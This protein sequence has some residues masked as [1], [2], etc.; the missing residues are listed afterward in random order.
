MISDACF[1]ALIG[2]YSNCIADERFGQ[3]SPFSLEHMNEIEYYIA[4]VCCLVWEMSHS[5][6]GRG[7]VQGHSVR[8]REAKGWQVPGSVEEGPRAGQCQVW[9]VGR[10]GGKGKGRKLQSEWA[11]TDRDRFT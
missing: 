2:A 8:G 7:C 9:N 11:K 3:C 1:T 5:S 4:T 6:V 10:H